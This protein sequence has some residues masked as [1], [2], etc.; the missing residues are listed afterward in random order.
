MENIYTW[1]KKNFPHPINNAIIEEIIFSDNP[2]NFIEV[3]REF[4]RTRQA[5]QYRYKKIMKKL[6]TQFAEDQ[7]L[8]LNKR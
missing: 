2:R 5:I 3:G 1:A 6:Q 8:E 4:S 7:Q